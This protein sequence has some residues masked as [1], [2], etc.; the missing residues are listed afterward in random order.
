MVWQLVGQL[1]YT[2]LLLLIMFSFTSGESKVCSTIKKFQNIT[3]LIEARLLGPL[4]KT[5][6]ASSG[7]CTTNP[8]AKSVLV[9]LELMTVASS[10]ESV[11]QKNLSYFLQ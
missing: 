6:F 1:L 8:L 4:L 11:I 5:D 10:A 3:N 2:S 7:K 9:L